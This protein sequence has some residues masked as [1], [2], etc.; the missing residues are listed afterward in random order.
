VVLKYISQVP[1]E[2]IHECD[3]KHLTEMTLFLVALASEKR[4]GE[5]HALTREGF[6]WNHN[7]SVVTLG[8]DPTFVAK[9]QSK[10]SEA[11][12]PLTLHS[13]NDFVGNDADELILC[14]VRALLTYYNRVKSLGLT[15]KK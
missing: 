5:L 12:K 3:I 8:F 6:G 4:G 14:P 13:L 7:K 9:T 2:P 1:F 10:A 11:M 15:S